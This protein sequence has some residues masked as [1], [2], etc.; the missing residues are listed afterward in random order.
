[1]ENQVQIL[2]VE[3]EAVL[4]MYVS[5]LLEAQGYTIVDVANNGREALSL[6]KDNRVDLLLCDINLK[7]D[8]DGIETARQ[9]NAFKP[10]PV[11]Y[12]TAFADKQTIERAKETFPAAYL[13]KP[14]RPENLNIAVDLALHNFAQGKLSA[15]NEEQKKPEP[16]DRET[17]GKESILL[18]NDQVFI[19]HNYQFV[20][21]NLDDIL[22]LEADNTYTNILVKGQKYAL[23][24]TLG[25]TRQ[26][27]GFDAL[28]RVHRSFVVNINK[29]T[30]FNDR[31]IFVD[32]LTIPLGAQ[33]KDE[34]MKQFHVR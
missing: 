8:W 6:F 13:T 9:I 7:G 26:R 11:I 23:R 24:L 2:I 1:M 16:A 21:I 32:S 10:V 34:F 12:L 17:A 28:V 29:I 25:N 4:A 3:D 20:R 30:G 31:E 18:I 15:R 33:Y 27:L 14:V 19:K 5:D 22:I